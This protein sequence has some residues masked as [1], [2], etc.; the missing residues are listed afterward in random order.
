MAWAFVDRYGVNK[1]GRGEPGYHS[2]TENNGSGSWMCNK[3]NCTKYSSAE[4]ALQ[5][6][7]IFACKDRKNIL[8]WMR[9]SDI[10]LELL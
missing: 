1:Y 8:E 10:E 9:S 7:Q 5:S 6:M 4:E 3:D 2:K